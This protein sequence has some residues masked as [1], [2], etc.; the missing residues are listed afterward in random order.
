MSNNTLLLCGLNGR[1]KNPMKNNTHSFKT[2]RR[3]PGYFLLS[4]INVPHVEL[5]GS[6]GTVM[7]T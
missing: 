4:L 2:V 6:V 3:L 7:L 1:C 5:S